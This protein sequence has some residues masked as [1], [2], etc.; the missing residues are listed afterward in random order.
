MADIDGYGITVHYDADRIHVHPTNKMARGALAG[1]MAEDWLTKHDAEAKAEG[2]GGLDDPR[3]REIIE[4]ELGDQFADVD[5]ALGEVERVEW[6][7]ASM[8]VNGRLTLHT[9]A[10]RTHVMHFRRKQG[11]DF[12]ALRD[13]LTAHGA[14]S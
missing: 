13:V 3:T 6:R 14:T 8:L 9:R 12:A 5:L 4:R 11:A 7:D 2:L 1:P 10:G